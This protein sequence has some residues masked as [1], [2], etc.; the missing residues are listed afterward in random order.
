MSA[1]LLNSPQPLPLGC[2]EDPGTYQHRDWNP[3]LNVCWSQQHHGQG[4]G[5][6]LP[7][8]SFSLRP[9]AYLCLRVIGSFLGY[10][11]GKPKAL[12]P[13]PSQVALF[14]LPAEEHPRCLSKTVGECS[15]G[16]TQNRA[17]SWLWEDHGKGSAWQSSL[18]P[19]T[20]EHLLV[21]EA[22]WFSEATSLCGLR[23]WHQTQ[24][25]LVFSQEFRHLGKRPCHSS[26]R[27]A[28]FSWEHPPRCAGQLLVCA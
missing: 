5:G 16:E 19:G 15:A 9:A 2:E 18:D 10:S 4:M 28:P 23:F 27:D 12:K 24:A 22:P 14:S 1:P 6:E 3:I 11:P 25:L 21:W 26:Q 13:A 17:V 7:T 8:V 20:S